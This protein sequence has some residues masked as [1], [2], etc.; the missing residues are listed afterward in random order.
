MIEFFV[1]HEV[2][3]AAGTEYGDAN[4]FRPLLENSK[5]PFAKSEAAPWTRLMRRKERIRDD[6]QDR[7]GTVFHD[8]PENERECMRS[9]DVMMRRRM[10]RPRVGRGKVPS[11][12]DAPLQ[13]QFR[14]IGQ[15]LIF[16]SLFR[17]V[18]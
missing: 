12:F 6:R 4:I 9:S 3:H 7:H 8:S 17:T 1:D 14:K 18:G 15:A 11:C 13:K 2:R 10:I 16:S 5:H